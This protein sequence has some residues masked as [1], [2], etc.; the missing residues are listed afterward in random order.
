MPEASITPQ[1]QT[2]SRFVP[3]CSCVLELRRNTKRR[4]LRMAVLAVIGDQL[5]TSLSAAAVQRSSSKAASS[6]ARP[7]RWRTTACTHRRR[8]S[9]GGS[10]SRWSSAISPVSRWSPKK[11]PA[12]ASAMPSVR[13][14]TL[15]SRFN[16]MTVAAGSLPES[17]GRV[18]RQSI[19][20]GGPPTLGTSPAAPSRTAPHQTATQ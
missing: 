20:S 19:S 1:R 6:P 4:L 2:R 5:H 9:A 18:G 3:I 7:S 11:S 13:N 12:G 17:T 8:T 14:T 16:L 15:S 10:A